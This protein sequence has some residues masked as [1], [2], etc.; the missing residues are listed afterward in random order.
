MKRIIIGLLLLVAS[1]TMLISC[2]TKEKSVT[3]ETE[4]TKVSKKENKKQVE[5]SD[6]LIDEEQMKWKKAGSDKENN[7]L[8]NVMSNDNP[9]KYIDAY[10][11]YSLQGNPMPPEQ[12]GSFPIL[13][14][15]DFSNATNKELYAMIFW[16]ICDYY[17]SLLE[18]GE[19][20]SEQ[21][22]LGQKNAKDKLRNGDYSY[23]AIN[24]DA[25]KLTVTAENVI[26]FV[27]T[28]VRDNTDWD[29]SYPAG[30][31]DFGNGQGYRIVFESQY[32]DARGY[33]IVTPK[34]EISRYTFGGELLVPLE[35]FK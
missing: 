15:S 33:F 23:L 20:T 5:K 16:G 30:V 25:N 18:Q 3:K 6:E 26:D 19:I 24:N 13:E 1:S 11:Q 22:S 8:E 34:G 12:R 35:N 29:V 10:N 9:Q 4:M 28:Y 2:G 21:N 7:K 32:K 14:S 17:G 27:D 31:E